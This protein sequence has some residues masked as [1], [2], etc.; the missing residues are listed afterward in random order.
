MAASSSQEGTGLRV[1]DLDPSE[2]E[3]LKKTLVE[4]GNGLLNHCGSTEELLGKLDEFEDLLSHMVQDFKNLVEVALQPAKKALIA[5]EL[6]RHAEMDVRV[7]AAS[8]ISEII[9]ITAPDE[10]YTEDQ[11]KE[12]F[13]L[14]NSAF[15][16]L[17]CMS[18]RVYS[19]AVAMLQ[20]ISYSQSCVVMLDLEVHDI[21]QQMFHLFLDGIRASHSDVIFSNMENIMTVVIRSSGDSDELSLELVKI[22]L[23]RLKKENHNVSPVAMQL[24]EKTFRNCSDDIKTYL[25]EAVRCLGNPVEDYAEVVASLFQEAIQRENMGSED[26]GIDAS[27]HEEAGVVV[28][29]GLSNSAEDNKTENLRIDENLNENRQTTAHFCDEA[30]NLGSPKQ[31]QQEPESDDV[32]IPEKRSRKPNSLI[33]PEEGYDPFWMFCKWTPMED[34]HCRKHRRKG[35]GHPQKT[36]ISKEANLSSS[37]DEEQSSGPISGKANRIKKQSE[38]GSLAKIPPEEKSRG[39]AV[40]SEDLTRDI[41]VKKPSGERQGLLNGVTLQKIAGARLSFLTLIILPRAVQTPTSSSSPISSKGE[42]LPRKVSKSRHKKRKSTAAKKEASKVKDVSRCLGE[43]LVGC[44]IEVWWPLDE[45]FYEGKVTSFDHL[46]KM[47]RV[48]YTDGQHE[49]LDLTKECWHLLRDNNVSGHDEEIVAA[50]SASTETL[51]VNLTG[52]PSK[53]NWIFTDVQVAGEPLA[54]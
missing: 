46:N 15:E 6:M 12:F 21:V 44:K 17:A 18:G 20:T 8:C 53:S 52:T 9:R 19:K 13:Q 37:P 43:E 47:H 27:C 39:V 5:G 24:A 22:L 54:G 41:I 45:V 38:K 11:M 49:I 25:P 4:G 50:P 10:P 33:K 28:D 42:A 36:M 48:D 16:K 26:I 7:S 1:S 51:L 32:L 2:V 40:V 30:E 23:A 35:H 14:A 31:M 3:W 29:G 34:S